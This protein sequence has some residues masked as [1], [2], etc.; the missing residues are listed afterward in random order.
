MTHITKSISYDTRTR[1]FWTLIILSI[2]S[3]VV[4]VLAI[5]MTV[6]NTVT[7]Q[8]LGAEVATVSTQLGELEFSYIALKNKVSLDVAYARGFQNVV[9]PQ[10]I[11]RGAGRSLTMNVVSGSVVNR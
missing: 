8:I 1:A 10:Y 2:A 7:R 9:S 3:L 11:S 5:N 4:Y 6:R